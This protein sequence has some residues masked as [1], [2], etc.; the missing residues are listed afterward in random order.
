MLE[1]YTSR[2]TEWKD[3]VQGAAHG[4]IFLDD[5]GTYYFVSEFWKDRSEASPTVSLLITSLVWNDDGWPVTAL[6]SDLLREMKLK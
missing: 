1:G 6:A 5:D 3:G 2:L 4:E